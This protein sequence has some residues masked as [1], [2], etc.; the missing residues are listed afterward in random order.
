LI[1]DLTSVRSDLLSTCIIV[2]EYVS[3]FDQK[4]LPWEVTTLSMKRE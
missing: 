4:K 1:F 2:A 3:T